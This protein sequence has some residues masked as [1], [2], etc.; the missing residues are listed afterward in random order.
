M[1]PRPVNWAMKCGIF[2]GGVFRDTSGV[3]LPRYFSMLSALQ[4]SSLG[5]SFR[6]GDYP[7]I[8]G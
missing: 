8:A 2:A 4:F 5:G 3:E 7:V 6:L 1:K